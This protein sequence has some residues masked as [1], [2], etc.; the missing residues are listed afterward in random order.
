MNEFYPEIE[1]YNHFLLDVGDGHQLYIEECGNPNGQTLVFIHGGP[2]G[3]CS[4]N[5]RRFFDPDCYRIILFDQRGCGRSL[6][7]GSLDNN[8]STRLIE[9]LDNIRQHLAVSKW[10]VF[11][12]SWGSTLAL[13]YAQAYPE[14]I[15]SMVLRGIY[16]ARPE[17]SNWLFNGGG[18]QRVFPDY[19]AEFLTAIPADSHD[20]VINAAY[21]LMI[22]DDSRAAM[23][24]AR[25]WSLWET[26][27]ATLVPNEEFVANKTDDKSCW[28][29]AR[30]EAHFMVNHCFL[31]DDQI[32]NDCPKIAH[33]PTIIVHGRYDLVCPFDQA[34][35]LHQHLPQSELI[36]S[37][38]AGH[39]SSEP[40]TRDKLI[41]A[42]QNILLL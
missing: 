7:H 33:I 22:A 34:L 13:I 24:V 27:C 35:L 42:T 18:A 16:L 30:H 1:P 32:I 19:H 29:L 36:V 28:T 17:D 8:D 5:D 23:A 14:D 3:G 2:G 41:A 39:A 11:G 10:H 15:I 9:D 38:T 21:Q 26:R 25:A 37:E 12:G 4:S 6:P 31:S 40:E 20:D